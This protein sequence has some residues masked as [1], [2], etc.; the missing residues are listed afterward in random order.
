MSFIYSG[1]IPF[2]KILAGQSYHDVGEFGIPHLT[3]FISSFSIFYIAYLSA[4]Y[5]S[6]KN[7]KVLIEITVIVGYFVLLFQRQNILICC[8]IFG[9]TLMAKNR[10]GLSK[11]FKKHKKRNIFLLTL[12][13]LIVLYLM[14]IIGNMRYGSMWKWYDS[15]MILALGKANSNM[16][17]YIPTPYFWSYLYA[18]QPL[19]TL[20]INIS[21][22]TDPFNVP[23]L[24]CNF[25][26]QFIT[27]KIGINEVDVVLLQRSLTAATGYAVP[28]KCMGIIGM[29]IYLFSYLFICVAVIN[30]CMK[31]KPNML[32]PI[33]NILLY[34]LI[35]T[36]FTNTFHYSITFLLLI[37]SIIACSRIRI[38]G[39]SKRA[40]LVEQNHE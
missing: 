3:L 26:P 14:G 27:N 30:S 15:S 9:N 17:S 25:I 31:R 34:F 38:N 12:S 35:F 7:K 32:V 8:L 11:R 37:Y 10:E 39:K 16:P 2:F 18:V 23:A 20:N 4:N 13:V 28:G 5:A 40:K 24:F 36:V 1:Y 29:I 19:A 6:F 21:T 33:C 22:V